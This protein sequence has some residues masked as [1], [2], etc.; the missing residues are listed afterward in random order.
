MNA[1]DSGSYFSI[2]I[3]LVITDE[4]L[5]YDLFINSSVLKDREK[6]VR[7][8]PSGDILTKQDLESFKRKYQQLYVP[9]SQRQ[10]YFKSLTQDP[11]FSTEQ[12]ATVIKDSAIAYL[13]RIFD[14]GQELST[15][16]LSEAIEGCRESV[17]SMVD[18]LQEQDI[19]SLRNLIGNLSYHDFYTY[20]HSINVSM[21]CIMIL[22]AV[23]PQANRSQQVHAGLGG[24]LHDLGKMKVPTHILNYP[25]KLSD[26]QYAEIKKHPD[27][28]LELLLD[29]AVEVPPGIDL[30]TITRVI[31]EHHENYGGGGYPSGLAKEQISEMARICTIADFFDAITT[32][33]SYSESVP[34]SKAIDIMYKTRGKKIDPDIF[35]KFIGQLKDHLPKQITDL[36]IDQKFDPSIPHSKLP[37]EH[38]AAAMT[39]PKKPKGPQKVTMFSHK[40]KVS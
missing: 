37:I 39:R 24:L 26:E 38:I 28:G 20:D 14:E 30:N 32:K 5:P 8:Y 12:K 35:D 29:G 6:Y 25:G 13:H 27:Y 40:K 16:F 7:I 31:H 21:Y 2:N 11:R 22:K 19:D 34:I 23:N 15:E 33:R 36:S 1:N 4:Q 10:I 9:E 18:I 3:G 17:E